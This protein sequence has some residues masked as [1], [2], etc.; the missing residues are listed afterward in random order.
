MTVDFH[1]QFLD[2]FNLSFSG[3]QTNTYDIFNTQVPWK[4]LQIA[5]HIASSKFCS[6]KE[7]SGLLTK[8]LQKYK[9]SVTIITGKLK[10]H[11]ELIDFELHKTIKYC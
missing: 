5:I 1:L 8:G 3:N 4:L 11:Q 9:I 10:P 6:T 2:K 7:L